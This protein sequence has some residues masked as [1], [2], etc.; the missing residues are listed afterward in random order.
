MTR[1]RGPR[2]T[3]L[4]SDPARLLRALR[5]CR[6]AMGDAHRHVLI[7]G[8]LYVA[9]HALTS[10]IDAVAKILTGDAEYFWSKGRPTCDVQRE[11]WRKWEAIERGDEP[12]PR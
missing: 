9:G 12:W 3:D 4:P 7:G 2:R 1:P 10:A 5:T 8:A 6:D 11:H